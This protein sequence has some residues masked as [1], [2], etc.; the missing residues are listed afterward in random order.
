MYTY[1]YLYLFPKSWVFH[2]L[3]MNIPSTAHVGSA[4]ARSLA[5]TLARD[6]EKE[7]DA[8]LNERRSGE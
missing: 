3:H 6:G 5:Q 8:F 1:M 7:P 4:A 2:G